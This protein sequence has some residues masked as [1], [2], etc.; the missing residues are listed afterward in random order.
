MGP[1]AGAAG[2]LPPSSNP[3]SPGSGSYYSQPT[4]ST[5]APANSTSPYAPGGTAPASGSDPSE[6]AYRPGSMRTSGDLS[7]RSINNLLPA[8]SFSSTS[9]TSGVVPASYQVQTPDARY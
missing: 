4:P 3:Y 5:T 9:G 7:P 6:P 2:S 8:A 1:T